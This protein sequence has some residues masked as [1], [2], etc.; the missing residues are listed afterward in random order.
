MNAPFEWLKDKINGIIEKIQNLVGG[1]KSK[2]VA[3]AIIRPNGQIIET[4][5]SDTLIATKNPN[6]LGS[7]NQISI[8]INNPSVRNDQ[9]IKKIAEQVNVILN[10]QLR[11][12]VSI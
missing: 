6:K 8:N 1:G 4:S 5:P 10:R 11:G 9:D 12:R 3:D 2:K 7:G